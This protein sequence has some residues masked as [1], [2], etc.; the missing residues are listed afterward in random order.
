MSAQAHVFVLAGGRGTRFWPLSRRRR[1]KQFLDLTGEGALLAL[2][3]P[4]LGDLV[5]PSGQWILTGADLAPGCSEL[6]P[7]VPEVQILGEPVGRNTAPAVAL[8]ACLLLAEHGDLPFA[9]LPSD[10][11]IRPGKV[12]RSRLEAA[13]ERAAAADELLTFGIRP[14]RPETGYGYIETGAE[15]GGGYREV[16]A[17]REKPDRRT[18]E[19][20]L[21][22]GRH[23]WNS[24]MFVWRA[25]TVVAGLRRHAPEVLEPIE[26]LVRDGARPG[27]P[28][29]AVAFEEAYESCPSISIDF[30]LMEKA[31]NVRVL[32]ADFEW[33]D[34]GH[35]LAM[36][37]LWPRDDAGNAIRGDVA[38]VESSDNVVHA[39]DRLVAL[40]GVRELV[41]VDTAD[42]TFV[43]SA[44]R[45]QDVKLVLDVLASRGYEDK[46]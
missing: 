9:V 4:R 17:F 45:A 19:A 40:L 10:H 8:A 28:G 13:F 36:R 46:L 34:V 29:F 16:V 39:G 21:A 12:F 41:V 14:D 15:C 31:D 5:P 18:A 33:N 26:R 11:L 22:S 23:L 35:W 30:A 2:T 20:Y 38:A 32:P 44:E 24:G 7:L 3:L 6:A 37:E 43:A 1:P 25:G 27:T 42:V